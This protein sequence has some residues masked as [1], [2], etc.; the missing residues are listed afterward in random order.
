[1]SR[2]LIID[3]N[4]ILNRAFYGIRLLSNREG[5]YTNAIFGFFNVMCKYLDELKPDFVSVAFDLK[6]KTFRHECYKDYKAQRKGMPDELAVQLPYAKEILSKMGIKILEEKGYEAD[7]IIGTIARI[8]DEK[9]TECYILT[10]DKDD[11]QLASKTTK[12]MLTTTKM[13]VTETVEYDEDKVFQKYGV[14]PKEFIDVKGLM[15]DPSDN[16]PG[17][18]GIG[19][20]TAISLIKEYKSIDGVYENIDKINEKQKE[21]LENNKELAKMSLFLATICKSV[22]VSEELLDYER[23]AVDEKALFEVLNSLE[24][25]SLI[26]RLGLSYEK[27]EEEF[28]TEPVIINDIDALKEALLDV[29]DSFSYRL[30]KEGA[31]LAALAFTAGGKEYFL[32]C[33]LMITEDAVL[34]L[35]KNVFENEKIKKIAHNAK[36]DIV[37]LNSF[38][39]GYKA[40]SFDTMIGAYILNPSAKSYEISLLLEEYFDIHIKS[41][42]EVFQ[43][44]AKKKS[45]S[46]VSKEDASLFACSEAKAQNLLKE[47]IEKRL[48]ELSQKELYYDLELP[49]VLVLADMEICGVKA[50]PKKL[51]QLSDAFTKKEK[52][53]TLK[54]YEL[55]GIEFNINS[56]KQLGEV[57]FERLGLKSGKKTK[58]GYSTSM[59]VLSKIKNQHPVVELVLEYRRISKLNS[60]YAEGL[61][62][63]LS[64]DGKIHSSFNQTVTVTGRISSTEPNLQNIPMR[65]SEGREIR[66]AFVPEDESFVFLSADYSQ[67]ELRVLAHIS[68]DENMTK[69]FLNS[70]D[71]HTATAMKIFGVSKE[72]VT[73]LLR[74]RAKA[75]NFGIVY[76]MGE[77]S[78]S[79]DLGISVYEAKSYIESYLGKY[80]KVKEYMTSVVDFAKKNGFVKTILNRR[81]YLNDINASNFILRSAAERTAMNTPVQ[82]SAADI[83]KFAMVKVSK[84][85]K[86]E[87]LESRL[88]LQVHDELIIETKKTELEKVKKLLLEEM[89]NAYPLSVPLIAEVSVGDDWFSCK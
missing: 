1:M 30:Y 58:T 45:F 54:I 15:G 80:E 24:L 67:I 79:Q 73:P 56:P 10:G 37:F 52:E 62:T 85:L 84:R 83:I 68:G 38:G 5:V 23:K 7:D 34:S 27:K 3:G 6:H 36:A 20:K 2:F 89:E 50:D 77:F 86:S 35:L 11:L 60:T 42:E 70:E 13:G 12:V 4:S 39:I 17:V 88:V 48:C 8:C 82:G 55:S 46:D 66:K 69:D 65:S 78:L 75:V 32:T 72:E 28:K 76:G 57:L 9:G 61:K 21:T 64:S 81:R 47:H 63:N 16:I 29:T 22:P 40:L 87:N 26:G 41:E 25:K 51:S 74:T 49:L 44:G 19:E 14:T 31:D 43:K 18:P 33:S 59:D 53:L 71:I